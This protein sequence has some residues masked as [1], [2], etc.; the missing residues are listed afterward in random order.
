VE[1]A[2]DGRVRGRWHRQLEDGRIECGVCPRHC[3]LREGQR[4]YCF[5]R[6][7]EAG[8]LWL[9]TWGR[10][11]ALALDPIEKKPLYHFYPGTS[12]LS[13]GTAGC[14]LGC[15]GCQN[16]ELSRSRD[17]EA[18]TTE[19]DPTRLVEMARHL[20]APSVAFTYNE[21]I[22][23]AEYAIDVAKACREAGIRTVAVSAGFV[24]AAPRKALFSA[25]D[26]ANIDLKS[27]DG[28]F[29]RRF[30]HARLEPVLE[31][32]EY[33]AHETGTW[34]ELTTLLVPGCND[35]ESQVA[36]LSE[37]VVDHLGPNVPL[38][39]SAFHPAYRLAQY[40]QTPPAI[41][42]RASRIAKARGIRHVYEG[43]VGTTRGQ[44]TV[45]GGC[46][47][48]LI[49]RQGYHIAKLDLDDGRCPSCHL[50]IPGRF[51]RD[52]RC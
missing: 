11:Q 51:M 5:V 50:A 17:V 36:A 42:E 21:P 31:T 33:I 20:Q 29:Y 18:R 43:N 37:W 48:V 40:P 13:L 44:A 28:E 3:R 26:A 49:N 45:C 30:C 1:R 32:L 34:L 6:Q 9:T 7:H 22:V 39:F 14:N 16:W 4:G 8:D 27:M 35:S 38:H 23:F 47:R 19:M 15:L 52:A 25:I 41:C 24:E 10:A 46:Q 2:L 12:C